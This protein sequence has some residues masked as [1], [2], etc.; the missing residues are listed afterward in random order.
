MGIFKNIFG[1]NQHLTDVAG[2]MEYPNPVWS[3]QHAKY[4]VLYD[5]FSGKALDETIDSG[6][7]N[8]VPKYPIKI[9]ICRQIALTQA[10]IL[11]GEWQDNVF[12]WRTPD[13]NGP[14]AQMKFLRKTF[15]ASRMNSQYIKQAITHS[16]LGNM[17]WKIQTS[18]TGM[19]WVPIAPESFYPVFSA[20]DDELIEL[21]VS[22]QITGREANMK[23]QVGSD[24]DVEM[25]IEHWTQDKY[26]VTV[27]D[28]VVRE[29]PTIMGVI[30][31]EHIQRLNVTGESYGI[32][33]IEDV[34]GIQNEM[35]ARLADIGD[36]VGRETHKDMVVSGIANGHKGITRSKNIIDLGVG[37]GT[38]PKVH[39]Y[40]KAI[41]PQ[42]SFE[43]LA[44]INDYTMT[45]T[46]VPP[47]SFGIDEGSQR[48]SMTLN[49]RM[50]P[51]VQSGK[52]NRAFVID[53]MA[54]LATKTLTL[55][56][57]GMLID[58]EVGY[59]EPDLPNMLP[60]DHEASVNEVVQLS[61]IGLISDERAVNVLG[62]PEAEQPEEIKRIQALRTEERNFAQQ[63]Q[64]AKSAQAG[65]GERSGGKDVGGNVKANGS[66]SKDTKPGAN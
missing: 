14:D 33:S 27:G 19:K 6:D 11:I 2:P 21:F 16:V 42:G 9:N 4:Q 29:G 38:T 24:N 58:G 45:T 36:A 39:E 8:F 30:P 28:K 12:D 23:Y 43:M 26:K 54:R 64:L 50:W 15:L 47:V 55:A 5:Y 13:G 57:A 52:V 49:F 61:S 60:R 1:S 22:T 25:Y 48:S 66:A 32:S 59:F 3:E 41:V 51:L 31:Y 7:G 46:G 18:P 34:I 62:I 40:T 10:Y 63:T 17:V 56:K 20:I 65:E 37:L 35:N 44:K 53:G